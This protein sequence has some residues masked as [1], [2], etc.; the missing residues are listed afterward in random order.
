MK[1]IS[2]RNIIKQERRDYE[3]G[4]TSD[5]NE[6]RG[7]RDARKQKLIAEMA[8]DNDGDDLQKV[9]KNEDYDDGRC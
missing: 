7:N 1:H 6:G 5:A 2:D 4:K 8:D 3:K 9:L